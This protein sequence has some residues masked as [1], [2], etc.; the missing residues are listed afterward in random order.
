MKKE[1]QTSPTQTRADAQTAEKKWR[2]EWLE[3]TRKLVEAC[4]D[5]VMPEDGRF[6]D[7]LHEK[8]MAAVEEADQKSKDVTESEGA[9]LSWTDLVMGALYRSNARAVDRA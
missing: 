8:I 4:D 5:V 1:A 2:A 6:Y 3:K 7:R 9:Q